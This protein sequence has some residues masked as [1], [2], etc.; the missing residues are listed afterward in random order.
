M[1]QTVNSYRVANS[2]TVVNDGPETADEKL[3]THLAGAQIPMCAPEIWFGV[4]KFLVDL[5]VVEVVGFSDKFEAKD[6]SIDA[7]CIGCHGGIFDMLLGSL[8]Q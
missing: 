3:R 4:I 8:L 2:V 5:V 7:L 6:V 1:C